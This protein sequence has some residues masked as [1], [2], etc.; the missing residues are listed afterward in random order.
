MA[1]CGQVG[2]RHIR[3]RY[4]H[5]S[6]IALAGIIRAFSPCRSIYETNVTH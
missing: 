6:Q 5:S 3:V 1:G 2:S 4:D